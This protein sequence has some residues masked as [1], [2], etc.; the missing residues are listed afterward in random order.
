MK[1]G[2]MLMVIALRGLDGGLCRPYLFVV[3]FQGVFSEVSG[4]ERAS[5]QSAKACQ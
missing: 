1:S 5:S 2:A 4:F 3:F